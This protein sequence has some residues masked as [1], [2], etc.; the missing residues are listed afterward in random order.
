M[1]PS[2]TSRTVPPLPFLC[3]DP[4]RPG[5]LRLKLPILCTRLLPTAST[6]PRGDVNEGPCAAASCTRNSLMLVPRQMPAWPLNM[7]ISLE[8]M[9]PQRR[10]S[11]QPNDRGDH[12]K[13]WTR[14]GEESRPWICVWRM[15]AREGPEVDEGVWAGRRGASWSITVRIVWS[16]SSESQLS[17]C[18]DVQVSGL[19]S[20]REGLGDRIFHL[21][22]AASVQ[23]YRWPYQQQTQRRSGLPCY[24]FEKRNGG[25]QVIC[26]ELSLTCLVAAEELR[27]RLGSISMQP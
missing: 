26:H 24:C 5:A 4:V 20:Q 1:F 22:I 8:K 23:N 11:Y 7:L 18:K 19:L 15:M 21:P 12:S 3:D 25:L 13:R 6:A 16:G 2:Y 10:D 9:K 17:A 27:H 14:R